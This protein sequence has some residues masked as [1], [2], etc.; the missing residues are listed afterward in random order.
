MFKMISTL[1][2]I[3]L[4]LATNTYGNASKGK[5][6][7][8]KKMQKICGF[9]AAK[10]TR[11]HT[12][13]EW[14]SLYEGGK[15]LEEIHHICPDLDTHSL[16]SKWVEHLYDMSLKYAKDGVAPNGCND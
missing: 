11:K 7:Y 1:C 14:E 2:L 13:A 10:M 15:F 6:I 9:S 8:K 4:I 3:F 16:Q 12:Q 5:R